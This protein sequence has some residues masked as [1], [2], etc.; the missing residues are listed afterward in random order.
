MPPPFTA[1]DQDDAD[2]L[3]AAGRFAS[4]RV[5]MV[6]TDPRQPDNPIVYVNRGFERLTGYSGETT[7]GRNCRF[8]QCDE[9]SDETV[10]ELRAAIKAKS[11]HA[12]VLLNRRSNGET[13]LNALT[14]SPVFDQDGQLVYFIG[15]QSEVAP[16]ET[17]KELERFQ[18][19]IA[20]IQHRVKNHLSMVLSLIRMKEN[21]SRDTKGYADLSRRIESLQLLYEEMTAG[22]I[23][24]NED[25][26]Q[27][28]T[29][30]GRVANAIAHLDGRPG[31]RMNINVDPVLVPTQTAVYIGLIVSEVLTNAMQHAFAEQRTGLVELRVNRTD[32]G[33]MRAIVSDD[34]VG[35]PDGLTWPEG[36]GTGARIV[37]GLCRGLDATLHVTRGA[38]G[39]IVML[40][41]PS[42]D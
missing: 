31:V 25:K 28:G 24:R 41:V 23:D 7:I 22:Q 40:D 35:L 5:A 27:L 2:E 1:L 19:A 37:K 15:L 20:E 8:L 29:Y 18:A 26:I 21:E 33:G 42:A 4:S 32:D 12:T 3:I 6:I 13:F 34:G 11:D 9:T 14:V 30:L 10:R 17:E 39:T 38:V 36:G 16:D